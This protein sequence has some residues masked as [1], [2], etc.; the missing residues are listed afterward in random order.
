MSKNMRNGCVKVGDT[1][2]YYAAFGTGDKRLVV[3]PGLSDGFAT[4]DGKA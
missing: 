2:M 3:L 1:D 4:V